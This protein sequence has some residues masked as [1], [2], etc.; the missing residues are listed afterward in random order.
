MTEKK[1]ESKKQKLWYVRRDGE[2]K[3]P[4]PPGAIRR[5]VLLGRVRV[6]DEVSIDKID[7]LPV[8]KVPDVVPP[9][10]R[11][12]LEIGDKELLITSRLREDER[13]GRE[14]RVAADDR[15]YRQRRKG[16]RRQ[17]ELEIIQ[18]HR[19]AKIDLLE[20]RR[21]K[22]LPLFS[23]IIVG[24]LV[25]LA[26]GFGIYLGAPAS[27]PDP[28]CDS[29]PA[30]GVNWRNCKLD[31]LQLESAELD[32]VQLSNGSVR[33]AKLS[34]GKFN[35]GDM[36][37]VDLSESDLSYA[38]LKSA[39]MKGATLRYTDLSYADLSGADLSF[40]DLTGANLGGAAIKQAR[41]DNAIWI[42]GALC[43]PGSLGSCLIKP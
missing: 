43:Q 17:A 13:N 25:L 12:A 2:I 3:G 29:Q 14:R 10:I 23:M 9:E 41:L 22:P 31:G 38:E 28:D 18:N 27:I 15:T 39:S 19:Q 35:H 42:N 30:P 33:G 40:A 16:E 5:F 7:W 6:D 34:G 1:S 36:Q 37:Y 26:V 4:H 21:K 24:T 32:G 8:S 11:K 20:R